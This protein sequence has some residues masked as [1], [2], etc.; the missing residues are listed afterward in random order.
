MQKPAVMESSIFCLLILIS[1]IV[2]ESGVCPRDCLCDFTA[3]NAD[4]SE[5]FLRDP[6]SGL[7]TSIENLIFSKNS[8]GDITPKYFINL[9]LEHLQRLD[10]TNN[11]I[12]IIYSDAFYG[13][14]NSF[15]GLQNLKDLIL[16]NNK[17]GSLYEGFFAGLSKL[18]KLSLRDNRL[19]Y[20]QP[21]SFRGLHNI[22][23]L[24]LTG[25]QLKTLERGF[26]K[27]V[28]N[29]LEALILN[30]NRLDSIE[31]GAFWNMSKLYFLSLGNNAIEVLNSYYFEGLTGLKY[32]YMFDNI[33]EVIRLENFRNLPKLVSLDLTDNHIYFIN[34][35]AFS[36][37][38][39]LKR[40]CLSHNTAL[41]LHSEFSFLNLP[42]LEI[43]KLSGCRV[44]EF[45]PQ[46][47]RNTSNLKALAID[48]TYMAVIYL[49]A[50][51]QL[52][53]L[54]Y[55]SI[56][57]NP[58][59]CTCDL[60]KIRFWCKEHRIDTG[61]LSQ[62]REFVTVDEHFEPKCILPG[63]EDEETA[64]FEKEL[65]SS[66]ESSNST[67]V[68]SAKVNEAFQSAEEHK[69][70][71]QPN[72]SVGC[73]NGS[74]ICN[75]R[76]Y[77]AS[78][79]ENSNDNVQKD[80]K[81]AQVYEDVIGS[82]LCGKESNLYDCTNNST[83]VVSASLEGISNVQ[84][85]TDSGKTDS[86]ISIKEESKSVKSN[87]S[88]S[89]ISNFTGVYTNNDCNNSLETLTDGPQK[90]LEQNQKATQ[91]HIEIKTGNIEESI[92]DSDVSSNTNADRQ[93][94]EKEIAEGIL[95]LVKVVMEI[96]QPSLKG[97]GGAKE[98]VECPQKKRKAAVNVLKSQRNTLRM[99]Q[100]IASTSKDKPVKKKKNK[101][102]NISPPARLG[103]HECVYCQK[104]FRDRYHLARHLFVHAG[105]R[106]PDCTLC[107]EPRDQCGCEPLQPILVKQH[108]CEFCGKTFRD[109]YHLNR[110]VF[111]HTKEKPFNVS[112][113]DVSL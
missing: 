81:N 88:S 1:S 18:Q 74:D 112:L 49:E 92:S 89:I 37:N 80:L 19:E 52:K 21:G 33:I 100:A 14:G 107:K 108:K 54:K 98:V 23:F 56:Q 41:H 69:D 95:S 9:H 43:L 30:Y 70:V 36:E 32:L 93:M 110:H 24:D 105:Q 109:K 35:D 60:E 12:K 44:R 28:E 31:C 55:L 47:F 85:Q 106:A 96:G 58:L 71:S 25:N 2:A 111:V 63:H 29:N 76:T 86:H 50:I 67:N 4:C 26:L 57:G 73:E 45:T 99:A 3:K 46:T 113:G 97:C 11:S 101:D 22:F 87:G 82:T 104:T 91:S 59:K 103:N 13:M 7:S 84:I 8:M 6:P 79:E 61:W 78:F 62:D 51:Q 34:P 5:R 39:L 66:S 77:I 83:P 16:D 40:L 72:E 48:D 64:E 65:K 20:I 38:K 68:V 102:Q 90:F 53:K 27:G 42:S 94:E 15:T 17:L 75:N 10:I